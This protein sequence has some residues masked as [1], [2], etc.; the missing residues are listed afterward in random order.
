MPTVSDRD[1]TAAI[2]GANGTMVLFQWR[3]RATSNMHL[4]LDVGLAD[5]AGNSNLL[6]MAAGNLGRQLVRA[7]ADQP[8][9]VLATGGV[10]IALGGSTTV[11]R[12]PVGASVG[13]RFEL[14]GGLAL[15][16]YVHP[17]ISLDFCTSCGARNNSNSELS[18]NFDLGV[19]FEV[20]S[21]FALRL[22]GLFSGSELLGKNDAFAIGLAW[23][24]AALT[25]H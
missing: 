6:I 11:L 22:A 18:L 21:R 12:I 1:Y 24:P 15:T 8:L 5:P 19:N 7:S 25:T 2:V 16:P 4:S 17:R 9:D 13:H 10:G 3:E 20:N 23:T 14:D